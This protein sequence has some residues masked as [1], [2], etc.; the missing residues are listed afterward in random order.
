MRRN[1]YYNS[2]KKKL[3]IKIL[4]FT[5]QTIYALFLIKFPIFRRP[6]PFY[7][8]LHRF[9]P[10]YYFSVA[11]QCD[12]THGLLMS[13][14]SLY[15]CYMFSISVQVYTIC[16]TYVSHMLNIY[17][18]L[19]I[20]MI[21]YVTHMYSL[22]VTYD[23]LCPS[24]ARYGARKPS[25]GNSTRSSRQIN[26]PYRKEQDPIRRPE[27]FLGIGKQT[28]CLQHIHVVTVSQNYKLRKTTRIV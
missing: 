6:S 12:L 18:N 7:P 16:V 1:K 11:S 5:N 19:Y 23:I 17:V 28:M 24:G 13:E 25:P 22:S 2:V 3:I 26:D 21:T 10:F 15:V 14:C 27:L 8:F 20:Y 9:R 4:I